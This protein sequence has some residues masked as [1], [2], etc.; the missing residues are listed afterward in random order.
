MD[1]DDM[2][3]ELAVGFASLE[4]ELDALDMEEELAEVET[5][6]DSEEVL[7][8]FAAMEEAMETA[9][10]ELEVELQRLDMGMEEPFMDS[11]NST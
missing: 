3:E 9:C 1:M 8:G 6:L 10:K 7:M 5:M 11:G 2:E 4:A